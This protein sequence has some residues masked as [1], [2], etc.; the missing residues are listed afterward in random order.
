M[1]FAKISL[2]LAMIFL[3]IAL[4][5]AILDRQWDKAM[6]HLLL[7]CFDYEICNKWKGGGES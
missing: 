2:F 3:G 4:C 5:G 7:L 1:T 6:F